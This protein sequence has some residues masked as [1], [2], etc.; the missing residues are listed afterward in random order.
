MYIYLN[1][2]CINSRMYF[3]LYQCQAAVYLYTTEMR[4]TYLFE[5]IFHCLCDNRY[6]A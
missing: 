6:V 3:I 2:G 5:I 1:L 4:I